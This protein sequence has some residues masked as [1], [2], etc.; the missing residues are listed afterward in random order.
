VVRKVAC[1]EYDVNITL[2]S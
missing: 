2:Q 1:S